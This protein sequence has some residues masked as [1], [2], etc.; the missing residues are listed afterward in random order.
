MVHEADPQLLAQPVVP[1]C[2]A[3]SGE[4]QWLSD[5]TQERSPLFMEVGTKSLARRVGDSYL[6]CNLAGQPSLGHGFRSLSAR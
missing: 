4:V 2:A 3:S 6:A 1:I 5:H